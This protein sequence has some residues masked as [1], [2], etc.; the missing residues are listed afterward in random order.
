MD[1]ENNKKPLIIIGGATGVG[2][3][4][5]SIKFAKAVNGSIISA[6]SMQV[7]QGFDIG[8]AKIKPE[9]MQ[10]VKHY[11]IDILGPD[12]EFSV[13]DF[14]RLAEGAMEDIY[15]QGKI[16]IIVGGT[17]FYIQALLYN[18]QF[19]EEDVDQD[20]RNKL[21]K[22]S[23]VKGAEY[24][25]SMLKE[26]D[27]EAAKAIP[28]NNIKRVIRALE[29]YRQN[30]TRI[31]EH[32]AEQRTRKSPYNFASFS[33]LNHVIWRLAKWRVFSFIAD[34]QSSRLIMSSDPSRFCARR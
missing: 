5:L 1:R 34:A 13:F 24:L 23:E 30:G 32:N 19:T 10:G 11:L 2:K 16:P 22:E 31:S 8:S 26:A 12:D 9:E 20:Y 3:T 29:F 4:D 14:K 27:P 17:G 28:P 18:I 25:H 6:D 33:L 21:W 7:F 15:E